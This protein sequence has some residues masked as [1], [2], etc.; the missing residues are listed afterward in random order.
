[1][2][3]RSSAVI[4]LFISSAWSQDSSVP[5]IE[6]ISDGLT[7]DLQSTVELECIVSEFVNSSFPVI[8]KRLP[9][10][11]VSNRATQIIPEPRYNVREE[12]DRR[13]FILQINSIRASDA[14]TYEC[15]VM[16]T[17]EKAEQSTVELFV[18]VPPKISDTT[19]GDLLLQEGDDAEL[20]C[21]ATGFPKPKVSWKREDGEAIDATGV[22]E[23]LG[24]S[25]SLRNV[26]KD[27]RGEYVC[28]AEN[29]VGDAQ[30]KVVQVLVEFSPTIQPF[31]KRLGQALNYAQELNC[32]VAAYPDAETFWLFE[33]EKVEIGKKYETPEAKK[34]VMTLRIRNI[35]EKD[36]GVYTCSAENPLGEASANVTLYKSQFKITMPDKPSAF[37]SAATSTPQFMLSLF[38]L[39]LAMVCKFL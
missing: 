25:L 26:T 4:L 16:L 21:S 27:Q 14:A 1:M 22:S 2:F 37:S 34:G 30:R 31:Q 36:Y 8:W 18:N 33:G 17:A 20:Y 35:S 5:A 39:S 15:E 13:A 38:F 7:A 23:I 19:T 28:V 10:T 3:I 29:G 9:S 24:N 11:F 12:A 32:Q 6:S